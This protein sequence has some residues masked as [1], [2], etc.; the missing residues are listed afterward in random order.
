MDSSN[1][2]GARLHRSTGEHEGEIG[3]TG[4][5][6]LHGYEA[7]ARDATEQGLG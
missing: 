2:Y 4:E 7:M 6:L 5:V 3:R 1:G